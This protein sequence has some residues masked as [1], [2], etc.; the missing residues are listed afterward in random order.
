MK[1]LIS[2]YYKFQII[3]IFILL[4][5]SNC[6]TQILDDTTKLIYGPHTT[7]YVYEEE[8]F[9][10][11][12]TLHSVDSLIDGFNNNNVF[13]W[14]EK[15]GENFYQ[16]LGN[17]G[18]ASKPV[19]WQQPDQI[20]VNLGF[21]VYNRYVFDPKEI[22]YYDT[23]SPYTEIYY[24]Q[25]GKGSQYLRVGFSLNVN[26][27]WNV[28]AGYQ[29]ITA[30]KQFSTTPFQSNKHIDSHSLIIFSR[31]FSKDRRYQFLINYSRFNHFIFE[32]GG[33]KHTNT[34]TP[35]SLFDYSLEQANLDS[36][37][38]NDK[39]N[40]Y[41]LYQHYNISKN[42]EIA[43]FHTFNMIKQTNQYLDINLPAN[44]DF[45][46]N[47][48]FI[49][50]ITNERTIYRQINNKIGL[51]G[52]IH[53]SQVKDSSYTNGVNDSTITGNHQFNYNLYFRRKEYWKKN[54]YENEI[55]TANTGYTG[56]IREDFVG[57]NG[58]YFFKDNISLLAEG[59]YLFTGDYKLKGIINSVLSHSYYSVILTISHQRVLNSPSLI[60]TSYRSNHFY[61]QNDSLKSTLSNHSFVNLKLR[62]GGTEISFN[63]SY[64]NIADLIYYDTSAVPKQSKEDVKFLRSGLHFKT[65]WRNLYTDNT[66]IYTKMFGETQ[67]PVI[68]MPEFLI[69]GRL[70]Y[71]GNLFQSSL[72]IQA[73]IE[74]LWKSSYYADNYMPVIHQYY[75][76]NNFLIDAYPVVDVFI[77]MRIKYVRLF[78]K[79]SHVNQG[80]PAN[81]YF[82]TPYYTGLQRRFDFGV[83]WLFFD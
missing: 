46:P 29:R 52:N 58:S 71:Q 4:N 78:L 33:I 81:G 19:Y 9:T 25:G 45:Y 76:Q 79:M 35:D 67:Q 49:N 20:G 47:I 8:I 14:S 44:I 6:F 61:W 54:E 11:A 27:Q 51:K 32:N 40:N 38:S 30:K 13:I 15:W 2:I 36:V 48:N 77:N 73:G 5:L 75:L 64:Y 23:K 68:R 31:F 66:F 72:F 7:N 82:I 12:D 24:L 43:L 80:Y 16:D 17:I 69:N 22:K 41:H 53:G 50:S 21:D 34:D 62:F 74:V 37:E 57:G 39:R 65:H 59:E 18:T 10:G 63:N 83:N 1:Q 28:G 55:D 56:W 3:L 42:G 70:Y 26:P 60:Q